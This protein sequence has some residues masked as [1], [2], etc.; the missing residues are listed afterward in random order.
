[1][2]PDNN[3]HKIFSKEE[4]FKLIEEKKSLPPEADDFDKEALEGLS[5]LTDR[6]KVDGLN[7]SIDEI[8]LL[9]KKKA[10][11]KRNIYILSAAASLVLIISFFFLLKNN[12]FEK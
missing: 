6:K 4:L 5:M 12:S 2:Q 10:N 1:M 9:E 8:L 11:K 7:N 3:K